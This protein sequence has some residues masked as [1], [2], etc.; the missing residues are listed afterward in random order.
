M[1]G[2]RPKTRIRQLEAGERVPVG[3]P[4]R[5]RS[6]HGYVRL[7]WREGLYA[8]VEVYEHRVVGG[9]VTSSEHVHHVNHNK[10]DNRPENLQ[11]VSALEHR[12]LHVDRFDVGEAWAA[13][14]GG[15]TTTALA[16]R[17]DVTPGHVSRVLR[18]AGHTL[19]TAARRPVPCDEQRALA[20]HQRGVRW[21]V[22]ARTLGVS[23]MIVH[24]RLTGLGCAPFPPGRS[25]TDPA[26]R[27]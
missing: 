4:K 21:D 8:Y 5:Y 15:A 9:V 14:E 23:R 16:T 6:S 24:R 19:R 26:E 10:A 18:A 2:S 12:R 1:T 22:I 13:Y 27:A 20:L 11:P 7:R 25:R 17:Y 3:Q